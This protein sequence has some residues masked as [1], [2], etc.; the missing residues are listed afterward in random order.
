V[1]AH[2]APVGL[3]TNT[4]G[5]MQGSGRLT[6][7]SKRALPP[8]SITAPVVAGKGSVVMLATVA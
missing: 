8:P 4:I 7:P 2:Q 1:L 3:V 5:A 6:S